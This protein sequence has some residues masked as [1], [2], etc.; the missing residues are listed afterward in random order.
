[1]IMYQYCVNSRGITNLGLNP[2][3]EYKFLT[4]LCSFRGSTILLIV[5]ATDLKCFATK[6]LIYKARIT[7][8]LLATSVTYINLCE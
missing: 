1:M 7:A 3:S 5:N 2:V 6:K 8:C 4:K